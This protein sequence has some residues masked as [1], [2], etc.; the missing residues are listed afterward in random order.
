MARKLT[1]IGIFILALALAQSLGAVPAR[2]KL[3]LAQIEELI[4][5][6][7]PDNVVAG[8]VQTRGLAFTPTPKILGLLQ[9]RGAGQA[10][11]AAIS[12]LIPYGTVEVDGL[13]GSQ[14]TMDGAVQG[15]IGGQGRLVVAKLLAGTHRLEVRKAGYQP[16]DLT[17]GLKAHQYERVPAT[18]EWGGGYLTIRSDPPGGTIEIPGLGRYTT[19]VS[20]LPCPPGTYVITAVHPGMKPGTRSVSVPAGKHITVEFHLAPKLQYL[21]NQLVVAREELARGRPLG[22]VQTARHLLS[23]EPNKPQVLSLLARAYLQMD[24]LMHFRMEAGSAIRHGGA[25]ALGLMHEDRIMSG[26]TIH[27]V[28]LT[29]SATTISYNP[30]GWNK[31]RAFSAPLANIGR[32]R[33]TDTG[34]KGIFVLRFLTPGTSLL[35][36]EIRDPR[37]SNKRTSFYF[38]TANS[39]I[40]RLDNIGYVA[41][42]SDS[43]RVLGAIADFIRQTASAAQRR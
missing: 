42:P 12:R 25:V 24:D 15:T 35:H 4:S 10:T 18:L 20:N 3:G 39:R 6:H 23:Y 37:R 13:P 34:R 14:V 31:Y 9:K 38:A 22:A 1:R 7:A 19:Q 41:S 21:Q 40:E 11:L 29:V 16:D 2:G 26:E 28:T 30:G 32:I 36:M 5:I 8:E 43:G 27:P 33:I 17:F